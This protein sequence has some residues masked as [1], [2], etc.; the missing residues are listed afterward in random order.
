MK[1]HK[2]HNIEAAVIVIIQDT[3][4]DDA[5][6]FLHHHGL[7][8]LGILYKYLVYLCFAIFGK[9]L[10]MALLVLSRELTLWADILWQLV[11]IVIGKL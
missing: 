2:C 4:V 3:V 9:N 11:G 7:H 10:D 5:V 1:R 6:Y 8:C